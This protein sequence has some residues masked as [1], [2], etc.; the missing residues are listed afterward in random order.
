MRDL[1]IAKGTSL[2]KE[3]LLSLFF[4][5][6][7]IYMKAS[8]MPSTMSGLSVFS[9]KWNRKASTP[10]FIVYVESKGYVFFHIIYE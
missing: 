4:V 7:F 5:W 1:K 9:S 3:L 2:I 8:F 10:V 6:M